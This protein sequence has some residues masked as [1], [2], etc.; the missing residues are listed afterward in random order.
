MLEYMAFPFC[1][2]MTSHLLADTVNSMH[3]LR[4]H[5]AARRTFHQAV[6]ELV[7]SHIG[8]EV[9]AAAAGTAR[10]AGCP[11]S[12][13]GH[14][15]GGCPPILPPSSST[16]PFELQL[17]S[18]LYVMQKVA[19]TAPVGPLGK[20]SM[21]GLSSV[22]AQLWRGDAGMETRW[23]PPPRDMCWLGLTR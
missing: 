12:I 5:S 1:Q 13:P 6:R 19:W 21:P 23:H 20:K 22:A 10:Q 16:Q 2:Q 14:S 8:R 11:G 9:G 15:S 3:A 17:T 4:L 7:Q 18:K